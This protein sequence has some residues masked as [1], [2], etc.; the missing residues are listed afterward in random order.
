MSK[1]YNIKY[2]TCYNDQLC[3]ET[4]NFHLK[5]ENCCERK[6]TDNCQCDLDF[7]TRWLITSV[8]QLGDD[9]QF[10]IE[11]KSDD[12]FNFLRI[13]IY[14][15]NN[16]IATFT[17]VRQCDQN[18]THFDVTC[19]KIFY[20]KKTTLCCSKDCCNVVYRKEEWDNDNLTKETYRCDH[21]QCCDPAC[22]GSKKEKMNSDEASLQHVTTTETTDD[23]FVGED[24]LADDR[25]VVEDESST[26]CSKCCLIK[27]IQF[28]LNCDCV[29]GLPVEKKLKG[30]L[31]D[32]FCNRKTIDF[33][34]CGSYICF[35]ID[36]CSIKD[37]CDPCKKVCE[38]VLSVYLC[39]NEL[40]LSFAVNEID[41]SISIKYINATN[42]AY[43]INAGDLIRRTNPTVEDSKFITLYTFD[44][45]NSNKSIYYLV[46]SILSLKRSNVNTHISVWTTQKDELDCVFRRNNIDVDV[47]EYTPRDFNHKPTRTIK[48]KYFNCI[49]HSRVYIIP[50]LLK[51]YQKPVVYMDNDTVLA[52]GK[53][54]CFE[55]LVNSLDHPTG[56]R[57]ERWT[58]LANLY[59]QCQLKSQLLEWMNDY[60]SKLSNKT[61]LLNID[62]PSVNNG[63]MI[64]QNTDESIEF[65]DKLKTIYEDLNSKFECKFNDQ[66]AFSITWLDS[67]DAF[68]LVNEKCE[69]TNEPYLCDS[70]ILEPCDCQIVYHYY[71]EKHREDIVKLCKYII[72]RRC[73]C[74]AR[75][76]PRICNKLNI[77]DRTLSMFC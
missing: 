12:N 65:L 61:L 51:T 47:V 18:M 69:K 41:N 28:R 23:L 70:N 42:Y 9:L 71:L 60:K 44:D 40:L 39:N 53:G 25:V 32:Q 15:R 1:L 24:Y 48:E 36:Y 56:F 55:N 34:V 68:V 46:C 45:D 2:T 17:L 10:D 31:V 4:D 75:D 20:V 49:G 11:L 73:A 72:N 43:N 38:P 76:R 29:E 7:K 50:Q 22:A 77:S 6:A 66:A 19:G 57:V 52:C 64:F 54:R 21:T 58:S 8:K 59:D 33:T 30:V 63:I 5:I 26:V 16:K 3:S 74:C 35:D 67:R 14:N 13:A 27:T 37:R 62:T